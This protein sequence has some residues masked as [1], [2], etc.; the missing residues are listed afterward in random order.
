MNDV[1]VETAK[2]TT[3]RV[4]EKVAETN[5]LPSVAETAEVAITVPSKFVVSGKL[6]AGIGVGTAL[7]VGGF[8]GF[9]KVRAIL[10]AK[11]AE[12]EVPAAVVVET[13]SKPAKPNN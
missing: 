12:K 3:A 8:Y 9:Q 2:K 13:P 1:A 6:L 5:I 11:K 10:A 7:G 4:A